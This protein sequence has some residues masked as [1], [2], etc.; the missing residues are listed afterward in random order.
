MARGQGLSSRPGDVAPEHAGHPIFRPIELR[1]ATPE[2]DPD[3]QY[4]GTVRLVTGFSSLLVVAVVASGCSR[5]TSSAPASK[6]TTTA[7]LPSATT[8]PSSTA[9]TELP[10]TATRS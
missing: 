10:S 6:S 3:Q 2:A 4:R 8:E 9:T 1:G 5:A 7:E